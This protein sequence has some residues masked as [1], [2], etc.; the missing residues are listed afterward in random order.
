M[1]VCVVFI[2]LFV[3]VNVNAAS[4]LYALAIDRSYSFGHP[5]GKQVLAKVN[6]TSGALH[7]IA[8]FDVNN[9]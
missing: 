9:T 2:L 6:T 4:A 3:V 5:V 7:Y 1:I 8:R